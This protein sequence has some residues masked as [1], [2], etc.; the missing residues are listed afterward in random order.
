MKRNLF[1]E[2]KKSETLV[3]KGVWA[4]GVDEGGNSPSSWYEVLVVISHLD[5]PVFICRDDG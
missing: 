5:H 2:G 1:P 3:G 4:K